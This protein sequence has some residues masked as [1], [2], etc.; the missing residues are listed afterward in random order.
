MGSKY[1]GKDVTTMQE[2]IRE[3]LEKAEVGRKQVYKNLAVFPLLS[4]Y[5]S[6]LDYILPDEAL[7]GGLVEVTEASD[8]GAVPHLKVHNKSP[9]IGLIL[10]GRASRKWR[11][12][13][14]R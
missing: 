6:G 3:Y 2:V 13:G 11:S 4:D 7:G 9:R 10:D 8:L 5:C 12:G 1:D 14:R